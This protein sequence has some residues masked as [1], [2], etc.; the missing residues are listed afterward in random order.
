MNIRLG[1]VAIAT[2]LMVLSA[3]LFVQEYRVFQFTR[4]LTSLQAQAATKD[5]L[6]I[7]RSGWAQL[8]M[9]QYCLSALH[10]DVFS[11]F[12]GALRSQ[13]YGSCA[14]MAQGVLNR[15]PADAQF[16]AVRAM[17]RENSGEDTGLYYA[18]IKA[19]QLAAP[20]LT[21]LASR[22]L[23]NLLRFKDEAEVIPLIEGEIDILLDAHSG[24]LRVARL[25]VSDPGL[26]EIILQRAEL[27]PNDIQRPFLSLMRR[28]VQAQGGASN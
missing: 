23:S 4:M 26:R 1:L 12:P 6:P 16:L 28:T 13:G 21:W 15:N 14:D 25:Y 18:D 9:S 20:K 3:I 24:R 17:A 22:R 27:Q 2:V 5:E 8:Q 19:S 10:T 7:A 11:L